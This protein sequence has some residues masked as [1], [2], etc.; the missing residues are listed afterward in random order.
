VK[1]ARSLT[2]FLGAYQL[3]LDMA[4]R[5]KLSWDD[6]PSLIVF[7]DMQFNE[8]AGCSR[9]AKSSMRDVQEEIKTMVARVVSD[10]GWEATGTYADPV[11]EPP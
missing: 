5:L 9:D 6:V 3:I 7:S 4:K 8:A 10:L 2:N 1:K 11:L